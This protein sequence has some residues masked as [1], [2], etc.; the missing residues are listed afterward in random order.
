MS[1]PLACPFTVAIDSREQR[2][3]S[4]KGLLSDARQG[5]RP[6]VVQTATVAL[7]QGDYSIVGCETEIAIERKSLADLY[8]TLGQERER[9]QRE[10]ERLNS[11]RWAAVVVESDWAEVLAPQ[12]R[13]RLLPKS[14]YRSI[15]A[16]S[17]RFPGAHWFLLP[18][19]RLAEITTFR[20]LERW[21][22]DSNAG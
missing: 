9:F 19:R 8:H 4:F 11:L 15:L 13:S 7:S 21:W 1:K 5:R 2:P 3:Y 12:E 14:V 10:L 20:L 22:R 16:W 18:G 17:Q 6:L